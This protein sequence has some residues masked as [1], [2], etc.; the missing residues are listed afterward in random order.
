MNRLLTSTLAVLVAQA[1]D[2]ITISNTCNATPCGNGVTTPLSP[3]GVDALITCLSAVAGAN[4]HCVVRAQIVQ[5]NNKLSYPEVYFPTYDLAGR[6]LPEDTTMAYNVAVFDADNGTMDSCP[7]AFGQVGGTDPAPTCS[8]LGADPS[9]S[10]LG[11]LCGILPTSGCEAAASVGIITTIELTRL[12][13]TTPTPP[14]SSDDSITISSTCNVA[15]CGD[16]LPAPLSPE[17][18]DALITCLSGAAGVNSACLVRAQIVQRNNKL[19]YPEVYFPT[20]DLAGRVLPEDTTMAY[21]VA[22][23]DADNG[24]MDSCPMAFGQVGGTDPAPTCS[25]LGADP[26]ISDLGQLCGILPTSGCEA[27]AS[28][29]IITTIELSRLEPTTPA[30]PAPSGVG[31]TLAFCSLGGLIV[32]KYFV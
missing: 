16:G 27:A 19:S 32:L 2:T 24:T 5:R 30:P 8:A 26:S 6:V 15:A 22:V 20:Y 25:A 9:I 3:E 21:N 13:P 18:V 1:Q 7:M 17:A 10:D 23:F 12:E 28:V 31:P 14:T 4:T 11:Q 29:G